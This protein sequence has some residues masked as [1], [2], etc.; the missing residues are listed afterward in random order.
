MQVIHDSDGNAVAVTDGQ[1]TI[2]ISEDNSDWLAIE[3]SGAADTLDLDPVTPDP[4]ADWTGFAA[5][6]NG[7]SVVT[8]LMVYAPGPFA[9]VLSQL[10]TFRH[11]PTL[12]TAF[13]AGR[14]MLPEGQTLSAG[15]V[16][17]INGLLEQYHLGIQVT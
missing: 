16:D 2:P 13:Q 5:A 8:R 9:M 14:Q 6:I 17:R 12:L 1:R 7:D 15:D 3:A 10:T 11:A 4:P